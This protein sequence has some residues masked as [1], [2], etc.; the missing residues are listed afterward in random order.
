MTP[1]NILLVLAD[2]AP[3]AGRNYMPYLASQPEGH[4]VD[5]P[6]A[7]LCY[8]WCGP[9]RWR[10]FTGRLNSKMGRN[11]RSNPSISSIRNA[12]ENP[13]YYIHHLLKAQGYA[14]GFFGKHHGWPWNSTDPIPQGWDRW[15]GWDTTKN[16]HI[17]TKYSDWT[18]N[19]DGVY[20]D[21]SGIDPAN[22]VVDVLAQKAA[23]W[24]TAQTTPWFCYL[25]TVGPHLPAEPPTRYLDLYDAEPYP[26]GR[27]NY[28]A[29]AASSPTWATKAPLSQSALDAAIAD[30][31]TQLAPLRAVD[32]GLQTI[33][34]A[35]D[36]AVLD[37]TVIV[38]MTDN[39]DLF[40]EHRQIT[41]TSLYEEAIDPL[42]SIRW[43]GGGNRTTTAPIMDVDIPATFADI[44]GT[45]IPVPHHGRSLV[46]L[47]D[48]T[49]DDADLRGAQV[50]EVP[51]EAFDSIER[52]AFG[53]RVPGGEKYI[54]YANGDVFR[55][56]LATDPYE[57]TNLGPSTT[58]AAKLQALAAGI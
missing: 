2:D 25:P 8:P 51:Y 42:M 21:Y 38:F 23:D 48:G 20:V 12:G 24:I 35:M 11:A 15:V 39:T 54:E 1:H 6:E 18:A 16:D 43:P 50:L 49:I 19:E 7:V 3:F 13:R 29:Q 10:L 45:R 34:A 31:R 22:Y 30:W 44:A 57:L 14:T 46:P 47:L 32:D 33:I 28:N 17:P 26:T 36:P 4:W 58:A 5:A 9:T 27:P 41:K 56:N 37:D 52:Q 55:I 53:Y 40:G